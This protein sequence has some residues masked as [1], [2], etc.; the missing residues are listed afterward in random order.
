MMQ[1]VREAIIQKDPGC[2]RSVIPL[3]L[4]IMKPSHPAALQTAAKLR[5]EIIYDE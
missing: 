3:H 2:E 4:A 5:L 1:H